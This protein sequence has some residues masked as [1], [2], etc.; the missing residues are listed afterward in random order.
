MSI[1]RINQSPSFTPSIQKTEKA[2]EAQPAT[3]VAQPEAPPKEQ[4][5]LEF[6]VE[7]NVAGQDVEEDLDPMAVLGD[8]DIDA[9]AGGL[10]DSPDMAEGIVR[11]ISPPKGKVVDSSPESTGPA[12]VSFANPTGDYA[13][14]MNDIDK[15]EAKLTEGRLLNDNEKFTIALNHA[16]NNYDSVNMVHFCDLLGDNGYNNLQG[17]YGELIQDNMS[18]GDVARLMEA[19]I[20]KTGAN[21]PSPHQGLNTNGYHNDLESVF[22]AQQSDT[23]I[24]NEA[25]KASEAHKGVQTIMGNETG[26]LYANRITGSLD[27]ALFDKVGGD[28]VLKPGFNEEKIVD[29]VMKELSRIKSEYGEGS[30]AQQN[31]VEN[32]GGESSLSIGEHAIIKQY[33]SNKGL[34]FDINPDTLKPI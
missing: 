13:S 18:K 2:P 22:K 27:N 15:F 4:T 3:P 16:V 28:F 25:S 19:H 7:T 5:E 11:G 6:N 32:L 34:G 14:I 9:I 31:L 30:E 8:M 17:V 29:T 21:M 1:N 23:K 26:K 33:L 20:N 10:G 12:V 24:Y